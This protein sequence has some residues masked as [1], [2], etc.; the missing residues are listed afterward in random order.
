MG[1]CTRTHSHLL[2]CS[3]GHT[4]THSKKI[5]FD[6]RP[7]SCTRFLT[8]S[9]LFPVAMKRPG[10]RNRA[11]TH[12]HTHARDL[13]TRRYASTAQTQT[14]AGAQVWRKK[15][16][17]LVFSPA[18]VC[19]VLTTSFAFR[20]RIAES[21]ASSYNVGKKDVEFLRKPQSGTASRAER[22]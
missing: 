7:R 12:T 2:A 13:H 1:E 20:Q 14:R 19:I 18:H 21:S 16:G 9:S 22:W 10:R 11:C 15:W 3:L 4:I 17:T 6:R 5:A 8:R